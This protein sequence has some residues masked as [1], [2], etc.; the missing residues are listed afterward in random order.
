[1]FNK[2][3][4]QFKNFFKRKFDE[5][6][7][8]SAKSHFILNRNNYSEYSYLKN[9]EFKVFSQNGEDG[10]LD[11]LIY[12]LDLKNIKFIEIGV[13][14]YTECNTRFL[15]HNFPFKGLVCDFN[16]KLK[17]NIKELVFTHRGEIKTYNGFINQ[18]DV[19]D[20]LK[21]LNFID[22]INL[23]SLDIDGN[24][25]YILKSLPDNFSD[26]FVAEYNQNFGPNLEISTPYIN[27]FNRFKYHNSG[28][29][30]GVSIKSLVKLMEKKGYVFVGT[31]TECCNAFFLKKELKSKISKNYNF[32]INLNDCCNDFVCDARDNNGNLIQL[33]ISKRLEAIKELEVIDLSKEN[34]ED[35]VKISTL[36]FR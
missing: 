29:C 20:I 13:G 12:T 19:F 22:N 36:L 8:L 25:Y 30:W 5:N 1:M 4:S 7:I 28:L 11:Y 34:R 15:T 14:D 16:K 21:R 26:I 33:P 6:L 3:I 2:A 27:E 35:K 18:D 24:D 17:N 23:F 9:S 32:K 31:N 10:I